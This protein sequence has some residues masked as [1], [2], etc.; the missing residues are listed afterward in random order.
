MRFTR[1]AARYEE[2]TMGS[3]MIGWPSSTYSERSPEGRKLGSGSAF[4]DEATY[5]RDIAH[6]TARIEAWRR[7]ESYTLFQIVSTV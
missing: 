1:L 5:A 6:N 4:A 2:D 3:T 7:T